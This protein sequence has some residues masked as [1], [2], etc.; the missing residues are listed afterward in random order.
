MT[1]IAVDAMGGDHAPGEI[2]A[3]A[4]W[5][6]QEYGIGLDLVGR[7]D[8]F[9]VSVRQNSVPALTVTESDLLRNFRKLD[10]INQNKVIGYV[11]ALAN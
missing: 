10:M 6:A 8:D 7:E 4:V 2:V 9:G 3:G 5:A 1:R 11:Y